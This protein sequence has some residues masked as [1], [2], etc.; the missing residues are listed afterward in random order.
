[1]KDLQCLFNIHSWEILNQESNT[2]KKYD[3]RSHA[4]NLTHWDGR[5]PNGIEE[6][7]TVFERKCRRCPVMRPKMRVSS[8]YFEDLC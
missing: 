6:T 7:R 8:R 3:R 4:G 2:E 5:N 1:M